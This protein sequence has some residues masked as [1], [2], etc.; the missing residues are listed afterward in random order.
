ML[1]VAPL[2]LIPLCHLEIPEIEARR[3]SAAH[4]GIGAGFGKRSSE[5]GAGLNGYLKR[6]RTLIYISQEVLNM[7][8]GIIQLM[9][10]KWAAGIEMPGL[11]GFYA[12][13]RGKIAIGKEKVNSRGKRSRTALETVREVFCCYG[14]L[15]TVCFAKVSPFRMLLQAQSVN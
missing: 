14:F 13:K 3:Y 15:R 7:I 1:R 6:S 2:Q 12:V 4:Q 10:N 9:N 8:S 5:P 11:V